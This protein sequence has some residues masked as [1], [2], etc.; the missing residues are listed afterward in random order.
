M[1]QP[2][3]DPAA[4]DSPVE[5]LVQHIQRTA[6]KVRVILVLEKDDIIDKKLLE[7]YWLSI[8]QVEHIERHLNETESV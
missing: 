1:R 2:K 7:A 5:S 6:F 3:G 8:G 4:A